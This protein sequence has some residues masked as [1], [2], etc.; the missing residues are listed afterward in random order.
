MSNLPFNRDGKPRGTEIFASHHQSSVLDPG[1]PRT[2]L[3]KKLFFFLRLPFD[4]HGPVSELWAAPAFLFWAMECFS[5]TYQGLEFPS[6]LSELARDELFEIEAKS[7]E[8]LCVWMAH[9]WKSTETIEY[10]RTHAST[11][12]LSRSRL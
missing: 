12:S 11:L 8:A 2:Q 5:W 7:I 3:W 1:R 6:Q 10:L 9:R 4:H